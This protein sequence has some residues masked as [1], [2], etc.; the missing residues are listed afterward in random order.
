MLCCA[1]AE[2]SAWDGKV[3]GC[4]IDAVLSSL[5]DNPPPTSCGPHGNLSIISSSAYTFGL[6]RIALGSS[7]DAHLQIMHFSC[8]ILCKYSKLVIN[9]CLI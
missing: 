9:L 3:A 2:L 5:A 8:T 6:M 7:P 4:D 1:L